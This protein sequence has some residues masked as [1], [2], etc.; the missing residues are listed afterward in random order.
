MPPP[1]QA[2]KR[3]FFPV[4]DDEDVYR[5]KR[6]FDEPL[7][8]PPFISILL[9]SRGSSKSTI[10][11]NLVLRSAFY[12]DRPK[13]EPVF[14]T[15][16]L[17]SPTLG[18]DSTGRFLAEKATATYDEY[19]DGIIKGL[20]DFQSSLAKKERRHILV[21][22]DDLTASANYKPNSAVNRLCSIHRHL[23]ISVMMLVHRVNAIPP[24]VRNCYTNLFVLRIPNA[25]EQ[26]KLFDQLSYL[27]DKKG[28]KSLYDYATAEPYEA[29]FIDALENAAWKWG[30]SEPEHLWSK[31]KPEGGYSDPVPIPFHGHSGCGCG[32]PK[33]EECRCKD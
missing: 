2:R 31:Y 17:I 14:E 25:G 5:V 27:T 13:Q 32:R 8:Q 3:C 20:I 6:D 21:I 29:L 18:A 22:L 24:V 1:Q 15:I 9:G 23:L 19:E 7:Q 4:V 33:E 30:K 11:S 10:L 28:L 16:I 26:D 12:G